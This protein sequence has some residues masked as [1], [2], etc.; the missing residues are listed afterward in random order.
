MRIISQKGNIDVPYEKVVL[1]ADNVGAIHCKFGGES[2]R[3][4]LYSSKQDAK[5]VMK[6]IRDA[7]DNAYE[8]FQLPKREEVKVDEQ[9]N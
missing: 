1:F 7:W 4:G 6:M 8:M 2:F 3:M 9:H 5:A